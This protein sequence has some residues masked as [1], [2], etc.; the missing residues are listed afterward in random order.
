VPS[1]KSDN[2]IIERILSG[3][4]GEFRELVDRY[5]RYVYTACYRILNRHEDTEE[6][7]QDSFIKAYRSLSKFDGRSKFSTWLFRIAVNTSLSMRRKHVIK[8]E[9]IEDFK[10]EKHAYS[11]TNL[12][13]KEEQKIYLQK[14]MAQLS[15]D[16]VVLITLF[17][18]DQ[19]RLDEIAEILNLEANNVKV[20][21]FRARKRLAEKMTVIL[22]D[23]VKSLI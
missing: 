17:H 5:N 18:L 1:K 12:L 4:E 16:D 21:L 3:K 2:E 13:Q 6:A 9:E 8:S 22:K 19:L 7:V 20:K 15:E 14:A 11:Q 10:V 23:E